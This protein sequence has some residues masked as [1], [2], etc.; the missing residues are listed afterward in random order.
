MYTSPLYCSLSIFSTEKYFLKLSLPKVQT[1]L[2]A[3]MYTA[4]FWLLA[5]VD[6]SSAVVCDESKCGIYYFYISCKQGYRPVFA[7][8]NCCATCEEVLGKGERCEIRDE[9]AGGSAGSSRAKRSATEPA[10]GNTGTT[11]AIQSTPPPVVD[12]DYSYARCGPGLV[13][14]PKT[15]T[16]VSAAG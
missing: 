14:S 6:Y 5:F 2:K 11:S 12:V 7:A 13:C 3:S 1:I 15:N 10:D 8:C 9:S 16:C 4:I